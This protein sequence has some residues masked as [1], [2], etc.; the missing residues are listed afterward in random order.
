MLVTIISSII[1][2]I[3]TSIDNIF[4]LLILFAEMKKDSLKDIILGQY[5][6]FTILIVI[7]L[8]G[9][10]GLTFIPQQWIG[11]LGLIPM[12]LG[13][14]ALFKDEEDDEGDEIVES[15]GKF[16]KLFFSVTF[17][18][19]AASGDNLGVYIPYFTTLNISE[20]VVTLITFYILVAVLCYISYKLASFKYISE[21]IEKFERIIVPIVFIALG[22]MIMYE[23]GT[24]NILFN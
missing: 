17:I 18:S 9:A 3:A 14:K 5:V 6:G 20:L 7:S 13:F 23:N 15:A 8:L 1:A 12:Y 22:I 10:F 2:Y 19:L 16:S 11:L 21:A 4:I 24:F